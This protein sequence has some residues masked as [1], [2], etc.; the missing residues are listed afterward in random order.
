LSARQDQ[1]RGDLLGTQR[2]ETPRAR[3]RGQIPVVQYGDGVPW[4]FD[5]R[6]LDRWINEKKQ[7][8]PL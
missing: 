4:L 7:I 3:S 1:G 6:D 5:L 2:M 8:V